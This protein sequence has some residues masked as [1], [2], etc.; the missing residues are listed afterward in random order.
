MASNLP[1][2]SVPATWQAASK[3][4]AVPLRHVD[5]TLK[6]KFHFWQGGRLHT[7]PEIDAL[8]FLQHILLDANALFCRGCGANGA[9]STAL[10]F[11]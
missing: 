7:E 5:K 3:E 1:A 2:K 9:A 8:H 6:Q 4:E 10:H 11:F